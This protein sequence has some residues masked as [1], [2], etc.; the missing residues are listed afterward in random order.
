MTQEAH[1]KQ[2]KKKLWVLSY[3]TMISFALQ[4]FYDIVDMAWVGQISKEA[5]SGVT[6]FSTVY[7]L[8]TVLNEVAGSSSVSMISQSYGRNDPDRTQLIAEQTIS[9][10]VVLAL[11][12]GICLALFLRPILSLYTS[13]PRVTE[14]AFQYGTI[15]IFFI[16]V[17]F[18]SYS[19]NTIFRCTY[20]AKTPMRIMIISAVLNIVLDP[21]FIFKTVPGTSIPGLGLGVFGAA[22]ATVIATSIAFLYGFFILVSGRRAVTI[23][24]RGLFRLHPQID[25]SLLTVGLPSGLQMLIRQLFGA[26]LIF[27]VT[28]YGNEAIAL[29]GINGK[30]MNFSLMPIFGMTMAG[31]TLIGTALGRE[32]VKEA[33]LVSRIAANLNVRIVSCIA[34]IASLFPSVIMQLFTADPIV[35]SEG[36]YMIRT[37]SVTMVICAYSFGRRAVFNGSGYNRPQLYSS[38]ISRWCIQLPMMLL[39]VSVLHLPLR[40][41]WLT[42]VFSDAVELLIILYHCRKG[43]WKKTRV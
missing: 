29:A 41:F 10:K 26:V 3:P 8:F 40:F 35:L 31:S 25:R 24:L 38:L 34:L 20:D 32:D 7:M 5:L 27:F 39:I 11:I 12:S 17:M 14:A 43:V 28:S 37:I 16:P 2:L 18:S 22:L 15:R 36:T 13:D 33:M 23:S 4:S 9:F 42:Y 6:L 30:L 19:V 1:T 21:L